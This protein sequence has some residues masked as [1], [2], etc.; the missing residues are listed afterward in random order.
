[1][2]KTV[3]TP[4][5]FTRFA[6]R[7][8]KAFQ[9]QSIKYSL[10]KSQELLSKTLGYKN[11]FEIKNSFINPEHDFVII[12]DEK[13]DYYLTRFMN[14]SEQDPKKSKIIFDEAFSIN[15]VF[16]ENSTQTICRVIKSIM[17]IAAKDNLFK[18]V[19]F[20]L[21]EKSSSSFIFA[22]EN[23]EHYN[24]KIDKFNI[25]EYNN[26]NNFKKPN[27]YLEHHPF[28]YAIYDSE[29]FYDYL[30]LMDE[31]LAFD[32][33]TLLKVFRDNKNI[34]LSSYNGIYILKFEHPE[35][36]FINNEIYQRYYLVSTLEMVSTFSKLEAIPFELMAKSLKILKTPSN[37]ISSE[38]HKRFIDFSSQIK[39]IYNNKGYL[40]K[41]NDYVILECYINVPKISCHNNLENEINGNTK[42]LY[43][44]HYSFDNAKEKLSS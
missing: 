2:S 41:N 12:N 32:N 40:R 10:S 24:R 26:I 18:K 20:S 28:I 6:K 37:I 4:I 27:Q 21:H 5:N 39:D 44:N 35:V 19:S 43:S 23:N 31:L 33:K 14:L 7:I 29:Y 1:M 8:N 42:I 16:R 22:R 9:E 11:F 30:K 25:E 13:Y 3:V 38:K 15:K 36:I 34:F 17:E